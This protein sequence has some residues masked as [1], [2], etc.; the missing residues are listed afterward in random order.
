MIF[1]RSETCLINGFRLMHG[2]LTRNG[3]GVGTDYDKM[4][5]KRSQRLKPEKLQVKRTAGAMSAVLNCAYMTAVLD[6][7]RA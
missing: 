1:S 6:L 3:I 7:H 5:E 4:S 2:E